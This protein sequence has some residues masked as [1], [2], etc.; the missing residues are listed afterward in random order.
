MARRGALPSV[1][2][3]EDYRAFLRDH[4]VAKKRFERGYSYAVFAR[5][6]GVSRSHYQMVAEGRRPLSPRS[7]L[8][9][10]RGM[11]LNEEQAA[12]FGLLVAH[13][14]ARTPQER[15]AAEQ[16][17][18]RIRVGREYRSAP[19]GIADA[20]LSRWYYQ[21][22]LALSLHRRFRPDP[23]WV[24]GAFRGAL[25]RAEA[26]DALSFLRRAGLLGLRDRGGSRISPK[27]IEISGEEVRPETHQ[28]LRA[29]LHRAAA[30][31]PVDPARGREEPAFAFATV[32]L[33]KAE[34]RR[35]EDKLLRWLHDALPVG[36]KGA[37][38]GSLYLLMG[39]VLPLA[40]PAEI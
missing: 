31:Y 20:I 14:A 25:S 1:F 17:L 11:R 34:V 40:H 6:A 19:P 22:V 3:Y 2:D 16:G 7:A 37:R 27:G 23:E 10:A 21:P 5:A 26:A 8:R 36:R 38:D 18:K 33:T 28:T 39:E 15:E 32:L 13:A 35:A 4:Y 12:C 30:D 29:E 9:Y 24:S